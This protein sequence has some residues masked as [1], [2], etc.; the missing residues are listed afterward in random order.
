MLFA[1]GAAMV[2]DAAVFREVGGF[3]ER[4]FMFF[5]DVDLGWR[6]W[7]LG[8]EVR[9]V[10][11]SLVYHRHHVSMGDVGAWREHYLLE[12]NALFTIYKN[13]DD[14]N[15]ARVLP[16][17]LAL[18]VRRG[19]AL[20]GDDPHSLDLSRS[21]VDDGARQ[22]THKQTLAATFAVD[23]FIE[24]LPSLADERGARA[25]RSAPSR[26]RDP[27]TV[28]QAA[29]AEHRASLLPSTASMPRWRH[30]GSWRCSRPV[31]G[32]WWRPVTRCNRRW[33]ARRSGPG[34]S[35]CALSREHDVELVSTTQCSGLE[36][37]DFRVRKVSAHELR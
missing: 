22:E 23:A 27:P 13:Y 20:G 28:P 32:S 19:V 12:R 34:R 26:R 31:V 37:P 35:R 15:L 5:E 17:A 16:A 11:A 30:S 33:P 7:L 4:Y 25:S 1:S 36:H 18:A 2:I 10:P 8:Y 3:D 14:E 29:P 24:S 6:L 21:A 9:Y